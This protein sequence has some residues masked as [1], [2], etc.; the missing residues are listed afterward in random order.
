MTKPGEDP[1][2]INNLP[3]P[4]EFQLESIEA[5]ALR[6]NSHTGM[7]LKM[8]RKSLGLLA[9]R[10]YYPTATFA[11]ISSIS[12][13]IH[14][15]VVSSMMRVVEFYGVSCKIQYLFTPQ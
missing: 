15:D 8:K 7:I 5:Y 10:Y 9:S 11:I 4:F 1:I 2:I 6:N 14:P 3:Y 12:F 13:L